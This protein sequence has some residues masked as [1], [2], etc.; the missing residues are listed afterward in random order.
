MQGTRTNA[1][2]NVAIV[3]RF[4]GEAGFVVSCFC[5]CLHCFQYTRTLHKDRCDTFTSKKK[6]LYTNFEDLNPKL[7]FS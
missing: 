7:Y 2:G 3:N 4:L 1:E 6:E 5:S